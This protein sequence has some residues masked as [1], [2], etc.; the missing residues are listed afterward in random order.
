MAALGRFML[1]QGAL[2]RGAIPTC[3]TTVRRPRASAEECITP[4]RGA[5]AA[6]LSGV[7]G[8]TVG[9]CVRQVLPASSQEKPQLLLLTKGAD[10][11]IFARL[12]AA[13]NTP[14]ELSAF[15]AALDAYAHRWL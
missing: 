8:V 9:R 14:A 12:G 4:R 1:A 7:E 13:A 15:R 6:R 10:D 2:R 5:A 11:V 3:G